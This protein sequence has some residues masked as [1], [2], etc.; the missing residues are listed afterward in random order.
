MSGTS[1]APSVSGEHCRYLPLPAVTIH[2]PPPPLST[3]RSRRREVATA[4]VPSV[5]YGDKIR[6]RVAVGGFASSAELSSDADSICCRAMR[7]GAAS[8]AAGSVGG[9]AGTIA[10]NA[11]VCGEFELHTRCDYARARAFTGLVRQV[12]GHRAVKTAADGNSV[13]AAVDN[14]GSAVTAAQKYKLRQ[15]YEQAMAERQANV[16]RY[17]TAKKQRKQLRAGGRLQ[18]QHV[19]SGMWVA[20]RSKKD[21]DGV[22]D[23]QQ[24]A[25]GSEEVT[26][27]DLAQRESRQWNIVLSPVAEKDCWLAIEPAVGGMDVCHYT[28]DDAAMEDVCGWLIR[29]WRHEI[30]EV[31]NSDCC[32]VAL[33]PRPLYSAPVEAQV[34]GRCGTFKE[35]G[36]DARYGYWFHGGNGTLPISL[37]RAAL[38]TQPEQLE[39]SACCWS[40]HRVHNCDRRSEERN[41]EEAAALAIDDYTA[42]PRW[43]RKEVTLQYQKVAHPFSELLMEAL[44]IPEDQAMLV[45]AVASTGRPRDNELAVDFG[46][47]HRTPSALEWLSQPNAH[48]SRN[49][50]DKRYKSMP[51]PLRYRFLDAYRRFINEVIAPYVGDP[52]GLVYQAMPTLRVHLPGTGKPLIRKHNDAEYFHQPNEINV[53]LPLTRTFG[54]NTL[55]AESVPGRGD[56]HPFSLNGAGE[57]LLFYGNK[58]MHY[59]LANHTNATRVSFDFR[60][61]PRSLFQTEYAGGMRCD[62]I[63]RFALGAY[64][65]ETGPLPHLKRLKGA[66]HH[67]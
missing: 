50:Y 17:L 23:S 28:S 9:S 67:R 24:H 33:T 45:A 49:I 5:C 6:L 29:P 36:Q 57:V 56:F 64:Y 12:L 2:V 31:S 35:T 61:V 14:L 34:L 38:M 13:F 44:L 51:P 32:V 8:E 60:V 3:G 41:R 59:T 26:A 27:W 20:C 43:C 65:G 1:L 48:P 40:I 39:T 25:A 7:S 54:S 18:L 55:W 63:P 37:Q 11:G 47:L 42:L 46:Q 19:A 53:W 22:A 66:F 58:C 4:A 15:R 16:D 10:M 21:T 30:K 62:G 52:A